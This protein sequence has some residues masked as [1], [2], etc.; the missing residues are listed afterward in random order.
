MNTPL[1]KVGI[2]MMVMMAMLLANST[3]VQVVKADDYR[4]DGRNTR[5][6]YDEYSRERGKITSDDAG[7]VLAGVKPTDS[8]YNY[9]RTYLNGPMYAPVTGYYSV[10]YGAGGL[11]GAYDEFLNG[12][13]SRLLVRRLSDMITG[14]DP[15][16]GNVRL[17]VKPAVQETAYKMMT[18]RGYKGAVVALDPK[19][20]DILAMVST[21][22]YDPGKLASH[23]TEKQ[24]AAWKA[25]NDDSDN[26]MLN[27]AI[28]ETY[29]PGSTFKILMTAAALENGATA[30]TEVTNAPE[31]TLPGTSTTLENFNGQVCPGTTLKDA[32]AYSC[33]TAYSVLAAEL[34]AEKLREIAADFGVGMDGLTVPMSVVPSD[35]GEMESDAALYQSGIGQRDVRMTPL[36]VALLAS[37]VA[38]DGVAMKPR[39]VKQLLAPDL[40]EIEEFSPE[41]LTGDA[42]MSAANAEVLTDMMIASEGN[43]QGGGKDPALKIASKTGTAEHGTDPKAT[44]PHAWYTAFAPHDDPRIAV[45]VIVESGGDHGLAATGGKVAAEIGRATIAAALGGG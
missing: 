6:L 33:N 19:T 42:A 40:S 7:Q 36:Q 8:L 25:Y 4:T 26:P 11:E 41:E 2:A 44:P 13:D 23:D 30:D 32:L 20:G 9:R 1:R 43:T 24:Q 38:N 22:S 29:P 45:A 15:R 12:S 27:R 10:I 37:T 17:T 16:G 18:D 35:L 39:L 34:G 21:P 28:R 5:V 3:Y 31:V 14:R